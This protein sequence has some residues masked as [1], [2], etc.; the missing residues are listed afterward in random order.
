MR[1]KTRQNA[2]KTIT[3]QKRQIHTQLTTVARRKNHRNNSTR[4]CTNYAG[5]F[6]HIK[7]YVTLSRT[8]MN[9]VRANSPVRIAC[10]KKMSDN[11]CIIATLFVGKNTET[12]SDANTALNFWV[13]FKE[14]LSYL[15]Q[16]TCW[17]ERSFFALGDE[18]DG[19]LEWIPVAGLFSALPGRIYELAS[20]TRGSKCCKACRRRWCTRAQQIA[21]GFFWI[22]SKMIYLP[23]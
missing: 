20:A 12:H 6:L 5:E 15:S 2:S 8:W 17:I 18:T 16:S 14:S 7:L 23:H 21:A 1:R 9:N 3:G 11:Y 19:R 4:M 22:E 10:W 13:R